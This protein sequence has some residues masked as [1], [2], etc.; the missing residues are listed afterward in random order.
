MHLRVLIF[1]H[2]VSREATGMEMKEG[3]REA[4]QRKIWMTYSFYGG[5][6]LLEQSSGLEGEIK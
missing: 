4:L 3:M 5:L 2:K 1:R 6:Y